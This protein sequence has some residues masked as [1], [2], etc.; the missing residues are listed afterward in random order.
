METTVKNNSEQVT[1]K[2]KEHITQE[3]LY[4]RPEIVLDNDF[5]LIENGI[6][7]S[8]GIFRLI[9][10]LEEQFAV[11]LEPDEVLL[12]NFENLNSITA[13]VLSKI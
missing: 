1:Q 9:S 3:F 8:M 4:D 12:E 7:D 5:S 10:F 13:F 11:T 2:I 6:I